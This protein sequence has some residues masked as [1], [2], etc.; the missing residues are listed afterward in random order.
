MCGTVAWPQDKTCGDDEQFDLA[1]WFP[2]LNYSWSH[3]GQLLYNEG[4]SYEEI[5]KCKSFHKKKSLCSFVCYLTCMKKFLFLRSPHTLRS[6][7]SCSSGLEAVN[8]GVN[9]V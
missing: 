7:F 6:L 4:Q 5:L 1:A 8:A 3:V 9:V 2:S